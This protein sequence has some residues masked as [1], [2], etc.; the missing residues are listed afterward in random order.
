MNK[1]L[2]QITWLL[3]GLFFLSLKLSAQAD[4]CGSATLISSDQGVAGAGISTGTYNNATS[5]GGNIASS[6]TGFNGQ[7]VWYRF[8]ARSQYPTIRLYNLGS[9]WG[10]QL[11]L[12]LLGGSCGGG[13]TEFGCANNAPLSPR[14]NQPLIINSTYYIRI[15][16]GNTNSTAG[17]NWGFSLQI[18]DPLVT[19]NLT[20][21]RLNEV[22]AR[23]VI[24]GPQGL[25]FPWEVIYGPDNN[26]WVTESRG[27]RVLKIDPTTGAK[28]TVLDL[29]QGSTWLPSPSD[30]LNAVNNTIAP[31]ASGPPQGGFAGMALHPNFLDVAGGNDYAYVGYVH[32]YVSGASPSGVIYRNKLVRFTYNRI[33]SRLE[34]P[35]VLCDTLPGSSD[36]NSQRIIIA[37]V[38]K[39]GPKFLFYASGDMGSGQFGNRDRPI[40]SQNK[41]SYEGKTLR[42]NLL[43][44]A[45]P[46]AAAWIPNDN[47]YSLTSA[48]YNIGMRNNQGFAYDTSTNILYGSSHGP[49]SDDEINVIERFKNYGHPLLVG[50]VDGNYNGNNSIANERVSAGASFTDNGGVSACSPIISEANQVVNINSVAATKGA[51]KSPLF[52]AYATPKA[53]LTATWQNPGGNANWLSEGWS[54]MDLYSDVDIPGWKRSLVVGGLK[55]GRLIRLQLGSNG[56][57][58]MPSNSDSSNTNTSDTITY[59]QSTNR[60]RDLAFGPNGKDIYM[61]MD[62][63]SATSG[64]GVGSPTTP[65]CAG[66]LIKYSFLGY[67]DAAGV[68]SI[69]KTIPVSA[70]TTNTCNTANPITIDASNNSLWVPITGSDGNIVAEINAMGQNLGLV[71]TSFYQHSGAARVAGGLSYL[72]RNITITPTVTTFATP[73]KVRLYMSRVEVDALIASSTSGVTTVND[74]KILKNQDMCRSTMGSTTTAFTATNTVLADKQQGA[75][76]YVLQAAIPSFSSFYF[77]SNSVVLPVDQL[78]FTGVLNNNLSVSLKWTTENEVNTS[79]F[80]LERSVDGVFFDAIKRLDAAG[81]TTNQNNYGHNDIEIVSVAPTTVYYRLKIVDTDGRFKYSDV[82]KFNFPSKFG[83]MTIFPNPVYRELKA[84]VVS[85]T[86][87]PAIWRIIDNT[88][89]TVRSGNSILSKG[90][91]ALSINLGPLA[92]GT[93]YL[94]ITGTDMDL[95]SRFVIAGN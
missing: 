30:T 53:T 5:D 45:D 76:N 11:K 79:Y 75:N 35:V 23:T 44:D 22:F 48:V 77:G 74:I 46:G 82:V 94:K 69:S 6:C 29:N 85:N 41:D 70:G 58:T 64:P 40:K 24:S 51:Y 54:G 1:K 84:Q 17:T 81:N 80:S 47:P 90:V 31:W 92:V 34:S 56:T 72:N 32:R 67:N 55:W 2:T 50:F 3:A 49:Y 8:V 95:N 43:P 63:S 78:F 66:C 71:T 36:H 38:V 89:R 21:S 10:T 73:V 13:F 65:A 57:T 33:T 16:K 9:S 42:F 15:Y 87:K 25:D 59:F 14:A 62:N 88:G 7:D 26:L 28:T 20:G 19:S 4:V 52:S 61:V 12:Q 39:N 18:S 83:S 68:S 91:N 27:Y 60:Y 93:Y 86:V 37:P